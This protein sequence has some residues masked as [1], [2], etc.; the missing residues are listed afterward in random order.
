MP[1]RCGRCGAPLRDRAASYGRIH[2]ASVGSIGLELCVKDV[3][4]EKN[5]GPLERD[6]GRVLTKAPLVCVDFNN[7]DRVPSGHC[8]TTVPIVINGRHAEP[9]LI[10]T[11]VGWHLDRPNDSTSIVTLASARNSVARRY[12]VSRCPCFL[13]PQ[14]NIA[15]LEL[16]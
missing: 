8:R 7:K 11:S 9:E 3:G 13:G 15:Q 5:D 1:E 14:R 16:G 10:Q 6:A 2:S 12:V 4:E